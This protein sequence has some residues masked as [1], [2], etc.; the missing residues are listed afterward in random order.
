MRTLNRALDEITRWGAALVLPLVALLFL[1]WPLRDGIGAW[2][3][4]AND[5][6][7]W[8][9]ALYV[10]L[11]IRHTSR[12]GGHMAANAL[13]S[14]YPLKL[15]LAIVR[16]GQ[17]LCVLPWSLFVIF[18]SAAPVWRSLHTLEA[19]PDTSNPL[20]FVIKCSVFLLGLLLALQSLADLFAPGE[21]IVREAGQ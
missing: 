14:R 1:Q 4:Q 19:F 6:A 2:S 18:S 20:Y 11:A 17:A 13:A 16:Y 9:F 12:V 8:I 21:R 10:A 15:R 3:R 5:M 7:Q